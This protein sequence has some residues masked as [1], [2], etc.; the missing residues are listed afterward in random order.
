MLSAQKLPDIFGR[1]L[2]AVNRPFDLVHWERVMQANM[3]VK[4]TKHAKSLDSL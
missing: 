2:I 3:F 4:I 1:P